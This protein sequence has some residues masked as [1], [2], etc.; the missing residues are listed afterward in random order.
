[1][2]TIK[3]LY[4]GALRVANKLA[5]LGP[6]AVRVVIGLAFVMTGWGKLHHLGDVTEFFTTLH[7]PMPHANAVF[8][9]SVEFVGGLLLIVGL[10][11][12]IAALFLI[13][14]MA[15]ATLTA[16]LPDADKQVLSSIEISYLLSFLWLMLAGGGAV[17][18][19]HVIARRAHVDPQV[20]EAA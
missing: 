20:G 12:R 11:T 6:L 3:N 8:V 9:A 4:L 14:V 5:W 7:I 16:V 17:S 10:G 1:M 13:G 2:H 15:V 19:D 18:I